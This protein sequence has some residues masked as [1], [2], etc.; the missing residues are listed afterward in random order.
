[1]LALSR[2]P[3]PVNLDRWLTR[4]ISR[5]EYLL[6]TRSTL[7]SELAALASAGSAALSEALEI[8]VTV[9]GRL[10][11]AGAPREPAA[12]RATCLLFLEQPGADALLEVELRLVASL[13]AHLAGAPM[14]STPVLA[15]TS[16]E[17]AVLAHLL[18]VVFAGARTQ[19][20]AEARW[21]PRLVGVAED[22]AGVGLGHRRTLAV[23]LELRAQELDGTARLLLPESAL[24]RVA[25]CVA[26]DAA[27]ARVAAR[28]ARFS[29]APRVRCGVV[30]PA[31]LRA[32]RPGAAVVLPGSSAAEGR[33]LGPLQLERPGALLDGQLTPV[34]WTLSMVEVTSCNTE[35]TRLD[36]QLSTLPVELEV[37]L[38][39]VPL[40]L[41]ELST[42]AP[43]AIVP[44]RISV[45]D[46]VFLRAGDRRIAR[47]ELVELEGEVAA[48]IL[49]LLEPPG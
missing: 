4:R 19:S 49:D 17:R 36:P 2:A 33:V 43:G 21:R 35:V 24:E 46:P 44:L 42:L 40:A 7:A 30:W 18:L 26:P 1:M 12:Q 34:G 11:G 20:V 22:A 29:F 28:R 6:T 47:A 23:E 27:G 45:G 10:Q 16:F 15:L 32:L 41:G 37:E 13:V 5:A 38:A 48:R 25:E 8:P 39:R 14:P 3:R 31:E 9:T